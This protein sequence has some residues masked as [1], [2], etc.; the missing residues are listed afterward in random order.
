MF[1]QN[2]SLVAEYDLSEVVNAVDSVICI[3]HFVI[4]TVTF[5]ESTDKIL[6]LDSTVVQ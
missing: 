4:K 6:L 3:E 1:E 2:H 5:V